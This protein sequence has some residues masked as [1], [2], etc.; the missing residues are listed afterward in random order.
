MSASESKDNV[1]TPSDPSPAVA[2]AQAFFESHPETWT[3][4]LGAP[5]PDRTNHLHLMQLGPAC[6]C[7]RVGPICSRCRSFATSFMESLSIDDNATV[8]PYTYKSMKSEAC[9][10]DV[11]TFDTVPY[12]WLGINTTEEEAATEEEPLDQRS[13]RDD[14]PQCPCEHCCDCGS[15]HRDMYLEHLRMKNS[16]M[17]GPHS[18]PYHVYPWD[19]RT[20]GVNPYD[21]PQSKAR[22]RKDDSNDDLPDI[23]TMSLD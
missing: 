3:N 19:E 20:M 16:E 1:A 14:V 8:E 4:V 6:M 23:D 9:S 22:G 12:K 15:C 18:E 17:D 11:E 13:D 10:E 21:R 2:A 7:Y 5:D